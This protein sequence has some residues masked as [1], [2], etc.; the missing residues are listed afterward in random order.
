MYIRLFWDYPEKQFL[1]TPN[2]PDSF[3]LFSHSYE[4]HKTAH[5]MGTAQ[6]RHPNQSETHRTVSTPF[7]SEVLLYLDRICTEGLGRSGSRAL[8]KYPVIQSSLSSWK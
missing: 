4:S 3:L 5:S 1:P 2:I 7:K 8:G 6:I